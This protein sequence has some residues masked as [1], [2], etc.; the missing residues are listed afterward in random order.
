[1]FLVCTAC[2]VSFLCNKEMYKQTIPEGSYK[3]VIICDYIIS[4]IC[5]YMVWNEFMPFRYMKA[6]GIYIRAVCI[7]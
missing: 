4:Y 6:R 3:Y 1:M 5:N 2:N 7:Q